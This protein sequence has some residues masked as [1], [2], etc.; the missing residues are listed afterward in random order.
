LLSNFGDQ[1]LSAITESK[2]TVAQDAL[3]SP[4]AG[5]VEDLK[6]A[7][8]EK[9][10]LLSLD[11]VDE[12]GEDENFLGRAIAE[13]SK[14]GVEAAVDLMCS[15]ATP[16]VSSAAA[17]GRF[18]SPLLKDHQDAIFRAL[19]EDEA[20]AE[21]ARLDVHVGF[22][23][24]RERERGAV[25][26]ETVDEFCDWSSRAADEGRMSENWRSKS[27][28]EVERFESSGNTSTAKAKLLFVRVA[29]AAKAGMAGIVRPLLM[30]GACDELFKCAA[31]AMTIDYKWEKKWK[32][33]F[34]WIAAFYLLFLALLTAL[35][36]ELA[37]SRD[38]AL[39]SGRRLAAL[40]SLLLAVWLCGVRMACRECAQLRT[41]VRD[42]KD[43]F[44]S[45]RVG[46]GY[47]FRSKWNWVI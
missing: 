9:R 41:S 31:V 7:A 29:G 12:A 35:G 26:V 14:S 18:F 2:A 40:G 20:V 30:A 17:I 34:W 1:A 44:G 21:E 11:W 47:F 45:V 16:F 6:R 15:A 23:D 8:T 42:G 24:P 10:V 4:S 39:E 13:K 43:G 33:R 25:H 32:R 36:V 27:S 22:L 46:L 37:S 19:A 28:R 5:L 38:L 3:R